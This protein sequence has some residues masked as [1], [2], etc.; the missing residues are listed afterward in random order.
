MR[1]LQ[2]ALVALVSLV[3]VLAA[4]TLFLYARLART[5][6]ELTAATAPRRA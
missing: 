5:R 2:G 1:E 3:A 4:V 6:A